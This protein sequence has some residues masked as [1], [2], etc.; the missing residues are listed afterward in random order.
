MAAN[1]C[2][3]PTILGLGFLDSPKALQPL[4]TTLVG[5]TIMLRILRDE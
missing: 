3:E 4:R 5:E 2:L 1:L